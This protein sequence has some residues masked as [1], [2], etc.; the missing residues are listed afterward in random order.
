MRYAKWEI[1]VRCEKE[2]S[3]PPPFW[4]RSQNFGS[5]HR[6]KGGT[7]ANTHFVRMLLLLLLPS[8]MLFSAENPLVDARVMFEN[9]LCFDE[10][11]GYFGTKNV[12]KCARFLSHTVFQFHKFIYSEIEMNTCMIRL[13]RFIEKLRNVKWMT[14]KAFFFFTLATKN[15]TTTITT[16]KGQFPLCICA[17]RQ[18]KSLEIPHW[19]FYLCRYCSASCF[20]YYF[21]K[22]KVKYR[23]ISKTRK[24]SLAR[25]RER[26]Q[27]FVI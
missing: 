27:P 6:N 14:Q 5:C 9:L 7:F 8:M 21:I 19:N 22:N 4:L 26:E 15:R 24:F 17:I 25:W 13:S 11:N 3:P 18:A 2:F 20:K 12:A 1:V 16:R 23:I 10:R